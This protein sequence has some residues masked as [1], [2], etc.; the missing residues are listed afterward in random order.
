M[1][2]GQIVPMILQEHRA[3]RAGLHFDL[4]IRYPH[5]QKLASWALTK[6]RLPKKPGDKVL[7]VRTPDHDMSWLKF[8]GEIPEGSAGYGQVKIV[9]KGTAELLSWQEG[10]LIIFKV[11]G[12]RMSGKYTLLKFKQDKKQELWLLLKNKDDE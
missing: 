2:K 9:Q 4:R 1:K 12:P 11:T 5:R 7:A 3:K 8:Q 6:A 10:K